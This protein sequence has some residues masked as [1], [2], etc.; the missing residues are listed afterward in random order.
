METTYIVF[1]LA[2][3]IIF[4]LVELVT[5]GLTSIWFAAGSL[6]AFV[7]AALGG[8]VPVQ[9]VV[10][11]VISVVLLVLTKPWARKYVNSRTQNTNVA[12]L[13]G[14]QAIITED[15][16]NLR[17]TGKTVI[18]GMDWTVRSCDDS[19]IIKKG[20]LVEVTGISGV[21]LIVKKA[22]KEN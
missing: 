22:E 13:V 18:G 17:Q 15:V 9:A 3:T 14:K 4:V 2:A 6:G 19:Q 7:V 16:D 5:V 10:F 1:W 8:S 21:K 20:E 11:I 12:G